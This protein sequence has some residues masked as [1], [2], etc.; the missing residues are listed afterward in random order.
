VGA[1]AVI[2][3]EMPEGWAFGTSNGSE[4]ILYASLS[5]CQF[6][7]K[8]K[9]KPIACEA[10][11]E[12]IWVRPMENE[13]GEPSRRVIISGEIEYLAVGAK[14]SSRRSYSDS[15]VKRVFVP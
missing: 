14:R 13:A 15:E 1:A 8:K 11:D 5:T 10:L 3:R 2:A 6:D 12:C 4:D 9:G 7:E